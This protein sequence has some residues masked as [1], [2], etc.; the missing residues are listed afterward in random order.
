MTVRIRN[1]GNGAK[2]LGCF[3]KF[4]DPDAHKKYNLRFW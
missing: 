1:K 2:P 3:L 4:Q